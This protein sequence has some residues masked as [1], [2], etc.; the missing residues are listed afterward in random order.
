MHDLCYIQTLGNVQDVVSGEY[1]SKRPKWGLDV[2]FLAIAS[3]S[4]GNSMMSL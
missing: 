1:F 4:P 3:Y 2:G